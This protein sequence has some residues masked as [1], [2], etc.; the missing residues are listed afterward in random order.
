MLAGR[1]RILEFLAAG[2]MGEVYKAEDTRLERLVALKFLPRELAEDR[3]S[4][5]RLHREAKAA[6]GLIH[7]NI[8]TVYDFGQDGERAFIAM[9][10]LEGE[11]LSARI[12]RGPLPLDDT[13]SVSTAV[14]NALSA[15][16]RKG[17]VHRDLKPGNIMLSHTGTKLLDF[18]LAKYE[19]PAPQ[20]DETLTE[21]TGVGRIVG[22]LP[23][24]PPEQLLGNE[25]DARGDIFAFGAVLYEM[26]TGRKAFPPRSKFDTIAAIER[27]EPKSPHEV[28]K[29]VPADLE[30]IIRRCL[31]KQPEERFASMSDVERELQDCV[32]SRG[33]SKRWRTVLIASI[34]GVALL[35]GVRLLV[36]ASRPR[37]LESTQLTNDGK[38]KCCLVTDGS[39]LYFSEDDEDGF[40]RIKRIPTTGGDPIT[41][42]T[43][44]LETQKQ[45]WIRDISPD[46]GS[47]LVRLFVQRGVY[48]LW[49]VPL[50]ASSS[51]LL[52]QRAGGFGMW[53]PDGQMLAYDNGP[54]F[55]DLMLARADGTEPRRLA[56]TTGRVGRP[57]WSPDGKSVRFPV[58]DRSTHITNWFE[59]SKQGEAPHQVMLNRGERAPEETPELGAPED[60]GRWS[61]D[62]RYFLYMAWHRRSDLWAFREQPFFIGLAKRD[63]VPLTTGPLSYEEFTTGPDGRRIFAIGE[64]VRGETERY[65]YKTRSFVPLRP[66]LSADCCVYSNDGR[67]MLYVSFPDGYLWRA[68]S[69]GSE[70]RQLTRGPMAALNPHWS[71]DGKEIAFTG[72][73]QGS[74]WKTF[75][76]P[77]EGG[78]AQQLT[79]GDCPE[80]DAN[81]SPDGTQI[82]F[83][84]FADRVAGTSCPVVLS[85][86]D[87]KSHEISTVPGSNGLFGPRW[88]PD[89]MRIVAQTAGVDRLMIYERTSSKWSELVGSVPGRFVGFP[90]W[91][92]DGRS[93]YYW[94]GGP[95]KALCRIWIED[96]RTEK[97]L[98]MSGI[99]TT[100]NSGYWGAVDPQGNPLIL[101]AI[102]L[103]EIF[104][105]DVDLP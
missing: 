77:A 48:S 28:R 7:P 56:T 2:G 8:C 76:I 10:Y 55:N 14:A 13:L 31:R 23:Y 78:E 45:M 84:L 83:G 32:A 58:F 69:D 74:T 57:V 51:R 66:A 41:I 44:S 102:T 100:G 61:P 71:P 15:A 16:H 95:D 22:T 92:P 81:W 101:R 93:I 5:E 94:A 34:V 29:D 79:R 64:S 17:I 70:R 82:L 21:L 103:S 49:S 96:H 90:Q 37:V 1:F 27:E 53:S 86:I 87:L 47:L 65:D 46:H 25:V 80:L 20:T 6:S 105:L 98:D 75:I 52:I 89:G 19:K 9:E 30:R 3:E 73:S 4:L 88:S 91:S 104:A 26:V 97:L 38:E 36:P 85:T 39:A 43:P 54:D 42:P 18:G 40:Q 67:S 62:G 60:G 59:V 50:A 72:S 63:P 35:V 68:R 11:T 24:M 12:K 33:V 99:E